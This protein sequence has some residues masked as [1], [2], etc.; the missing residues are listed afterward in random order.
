[1]N[2]RVLERVVGE[3]DDAAVDIRDVTTDSAWRMCHRVCSTNRR[4]HRLSWWNN[5]DC[6]LDPGVERSKRGGSEW[7]FRQVHHLPNQLSIDRQISKLYTQIV[8]CDS[9][10][11]FAYGLVTAPTLHPAHLVLSPYTV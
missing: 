11:S 3:E 6:K 1:M 2:K 5:V 9:Y 4:Q 7:N 8:S 10:R